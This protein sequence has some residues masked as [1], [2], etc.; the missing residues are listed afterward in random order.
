MTTETGNKIV[1]YI[2]NNQQATAQ[3]LFEYLDISRQALFA[4]LKKLQVKGRV[5]KLGTPPKVFY[6]INEEIKNNTDCFIDKIDDNTKKIIEENFLDISLDGQKVFGIKG[7]IKWCIDRKLEIDKMA[8]KYKEVFE[9]YNK[10]RINDLIDNT[11]KIKNVFK[12]SFLDK[13]LYLDF[14]SIEIFGKTKLGQMLLYSKQSQDRK[15]I[16]ELTESVKEKIFNLIDKNKIDSVAFV[17]PSVKRQVQFMKEFES[18]LN[19]NLPK[20]ELVKIQGDVIIPQK[21]L[22]KLED[23]IENA[24][25]TIFVESRDLSHL[26][27]VLLIDDALGS[28]ATLNETARKIKKKNKNLK[29]TALAITGSFSKFDV[30]SEV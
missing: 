23:R 9:R 21:T 3:E 2:K 15:L 29:I 27:N 26:K 8:L 10:Y 5:K 1:E 13:V 24:K 19:I 16:K 18:C 14:Y 7:F 28:G 22:S 25:R 6:F 20:I 12:E 17:P 11:D 4:Q 30:I